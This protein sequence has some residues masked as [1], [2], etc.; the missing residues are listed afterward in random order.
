[1]LIDQITPIYPKIM[2]KSTCLSSTSRLDA[3]TVADPVHD[4]EDGDRGHELDYQQSPSGDSASSITPLGERSWGHGWDNYDLQNMIHDRDAHGRIE[5]QRREQEHMEQEQCDKR[6]YDYYGS[7]YDQ[8]HRQ[9]SPEGG[10]NPEG[11]KASSCDM[12]RVRWPINFKPSGIEKYDGSTNPIEWLEVYQL[13][14]EA[15]GGDSYFMANYLLVCLFTS[16]MTWLLGLPSGS[17]CSWTHLCHL[18]NS[19]FHARCAHP[20]VEWDL[21][22]IVQKK[23]ESLW[24]F[25]TCFYNKKNLIP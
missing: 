14:I 9:H 6:D 7:Y 3:A 12:K 24:E 5:N 10:H 22:N 19:N 23:G 8:P 20:R 2:K 15:T 1:M 25:I 13:A 4:R 11:V 21:V 17:V 16:P 18:F